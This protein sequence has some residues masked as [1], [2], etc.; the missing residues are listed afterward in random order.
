MTRTAPTNATSLAARLRNL[1][2]DRD[3]PEGRARRLLGVMV[4]GQVLTDTRVGVVKG[5]TNLEVRVGTAHTRVSSDLD[6]VRRVPLEEFRDQLAA[7]LRD[8]W[9]GFTG[10]VADRGPILTPAPTGYPTPQTPRAPTVP[11]RQLHQP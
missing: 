9:E 2:R 8:G 6:T 4:I 5:A 10:I 1:C 3:I 11:G 7:S